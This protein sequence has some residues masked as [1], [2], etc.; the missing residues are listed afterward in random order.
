MKK[1]V[2][3]TGASSGIGQQLAYE[4]AS[5]GYQLMLLARRKDSLDDTAEAI[6]QQ[7][8]V[9]VWTQ[10]LD[11]SDAAAVRETL[12]DLDR[13]C[14][15]MDIV[16]AN[17]GVGGGGRVGT[18]KFDED[19]RIIQTNILGAMATIDTAM[20]IFQ[21]RSAG[22][23]V[24]ISSVA[25]L[26]GLP[27]AAAYSASKAALA[28]YMEALEAETMG[29]HVSVTTLFPGYIDTPINNMMKSRPFLITVEKGAKIMADLIERKV[30]R[31][32][33]PVYPWNVIGRLLK[34]LP[35]R[36]LAKA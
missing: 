14:G 15:G 18:G 33:V 5:R 36:F 22:H 9:T 28:T 20:E 25:G 31:S 30:T 17:A 27:G 29:S 12:H 26:R 3:I 16:I 2:C 21:E 7:Y 23:I 34:V 35:T 8:G 24:A 4:F 19:A 6:R 1:T 10:A 13:H 32:T 11:V